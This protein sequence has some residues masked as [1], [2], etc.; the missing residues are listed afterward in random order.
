MVFPVVVGRCES[1]TIK[2][3]PEEIM[4]SNCGARED[5]WDCKEM[6]PVN[7][8]GSQPWIFIVRID[9]EAE[10][11]ILWPPYAKNSLIGKDLDAGKDWSQEEKRVA[12]DETVGW[13]HRL[14]GHKFDKLWDIVMDREAWRA[15]V[16]GVASDWTATTVPDF[17]S[18]V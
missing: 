9:G 4:L 18:A 16:H 7:M 10:A 2:L 15:A 3:N 1:W 17:K 11:P 12:E 13:H 14:K 5:S 6:K 8:K